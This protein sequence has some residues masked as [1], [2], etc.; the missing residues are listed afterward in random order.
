MRHWRWA[1][2]GIWLTGLAVTTHT[3]LAVWQSELTLWTDAA[4]KAPLKPRPVMDLGRAQEIGGDLASAQAAYRRTIELTKDERRGDRRF[5]KASAQSNLAHVYMK[6]GMFASAMIMLNK[7]LFE[8]PDFPYANYN[9]GAIL[10]FHGVCDEA[11]RLLAASRN[12]DPTLTEYQ[13][14]CGSAYSSSEQ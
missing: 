10:W 9:K 8:Y 13:N 4:R 14:A 2:I 12:F 6:Q 7:A 3:R 11:T 5:A 1:V